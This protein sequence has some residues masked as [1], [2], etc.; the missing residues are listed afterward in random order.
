MTSRSLLFSS[1]AAWLVVAGA[2]LWY[3]SPLFIPGAA[4][5]PIKFGVDLVGGT[6]ISLVVD[7]DK[8]IEDSL[9]SRVQE[10]KKELKDDA[11]PT[12][13]KSEH[14]SLVATFPS[15]AAAREGAEYLRTEGDLVTEQTEDKVTVKFQPK[16]V[17]EIKRSAVESNIR[18]LRNRLDRFA[19]SEITVAAQGER[20]ILIELPEIQDPTKAKAMIGKTAMLEFGLVHASGHSEQ[21]LLEQA[22]DVIPDGMRIVPGRVR[23]GQEDAREYYLIPE[24]PEITGRMLKD[25]QPSY[26]E[27]ASMVVS[28]ELTPEGGRKFYELSSKNIGKRLAIVLDNEIISAPVLQSAIG[29]RGQISSEGSS[30]EQMKELADLLK[31]GAYTAPVRFDEERTIGPSLGAQAIRQGALA[32]LVGLGLLFLF[33]LIY[34]KI[35]GLLAFITLIMNLMLTLVIFS[36][37]GGTLT[38]PGIAGLVLTLGMAV[39]ASILIYE[40]I[41]EE[42]RNG[43]PFKAAVDAG[44]AGS[45]VVILDANA[46]HFIMDVVLYKFGTGAVQGFAL[47]MIVGIITTL[48]TGLLFLRSMF[49]LLTRMGVQQ[50]KF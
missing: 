47:T 41:K 11:Q 42:L 43:T 49:T 8:A 27:H 26:G 12:A 33:C 45:L 5:R 48:L 2:S 14:G 34:Y 30:P 19:I 17:A 46:T 37:L 15:V 3:L 7:I 25:A 39:D 31:S 6:Y 35:P 24:H 4:G 9:Y 29:S 44:F 28:F 36:Y 32:C 21:E 38:L 40:K 10:L 50:L 13:L 20:G 16:D 23:R 22:G 18:V 1:F